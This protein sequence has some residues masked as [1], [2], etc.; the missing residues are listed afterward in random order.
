MPVEKLRIGGNHNWCGVRRRSI[1]GLVETE[2]REEDEEAELP[3]RTGE[4]RA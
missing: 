1:Q 4:R 2:K 3:E